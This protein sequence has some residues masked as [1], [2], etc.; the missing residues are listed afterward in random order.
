MVGGQ[1]EELS[2]AQMLVRIF[3]ALQW[4]SQRAGIKY[5]L[6]KFFVAII[7]DSD[8]LARCLEC[9]VVVNAVERNA[10]TDGIS[11]LGW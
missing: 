9:N 6:P 4:F 3:G 2:V 7:Q 1:D 5:L 11:Q 10:V 8:G